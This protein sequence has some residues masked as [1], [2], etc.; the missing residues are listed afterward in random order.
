[1]PAQTIK[2]VNANLLLSCVTKLVPLVEVRQIFSH[3]NFSPT[4]LMQQS[5]LQSVHQLSNER[6]RTDSMLAAWLCLPGGLNHK[7]FTTESYKLKHRI[8]DTSP[9]Y[10]PKKNNLANFKL[11]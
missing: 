6:G 5:A 3:R 11:E 7:T 8:K 1:M 2:A 4:V 10:S 9:S